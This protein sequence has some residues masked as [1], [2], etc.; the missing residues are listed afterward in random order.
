MPGSVPPAGEGVARVRRPDGSDIEPAVDCV[1]R[2][3]GVPAPL[4]LLPRLMAVLEPRAPV[5]PAKDADRQRPATGV[6]ID[7]RGDLHIRPRDFPRGR[8]PPPSAH[9]SGNLQPEGGGRPFFGPARPPH[10]C[11]Q[12]S[13][14][15]FTCRK[16]APERDDVGARDSPR[17]R[18]ARSN[19]PLRV[20]PRAPGCGAASAAQEGTM[21]ADV[22]G[23][24]AS[25]FVEAGATRRGSLPA[26]SIPTDRC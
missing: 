24:T 23:G 8:Y 3:S 18:G 25:A 26:S 17:Y 16:P 2:G 10:R 11:E 21:E 7:D 4:V 13:C 14:G 15:G 12:G 1:R 22:D 20:D 19:G 9:G 6:R 5:S